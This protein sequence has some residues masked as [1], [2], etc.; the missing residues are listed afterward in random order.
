M[1]TNTETLLSTRPHKRE[2]QKTR[3]VHKSKSLEDLRISSLSPSVVPKASA[4]LGPRKGAIT[5]DQM[6]IETLFCR[7]PIPATIAER[8]NMMTK[9]GEILAH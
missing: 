8:I 2:K 7:S 6:M 9:L 4:T 3:Q 5:I 1:S